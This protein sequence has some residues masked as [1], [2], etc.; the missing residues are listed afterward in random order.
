MCFVYIKCI[1]I[2]IH[3]IAA[4]DKLGLLHF[5]YKEIILQ[6]LDQASKSLKYWYTL[7]NIESM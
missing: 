6:R 7:S 5:Y 3:V 1:L 2:L 4:Q